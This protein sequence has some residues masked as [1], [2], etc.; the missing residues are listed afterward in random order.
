[1]AM[2]R[3]VQKVA[4]EVGGGGGGEFRGGGQGMVHFRAA[5]ARPGGHRRLRAPLGVRMGPRKELC[6]ALARALRQDEMSGKSDGRGAN[7][8]RPEGL[9]GL[10]NLALIRVAQMLSP[11]DALQL[12]SSC[13]GTR[14]VLRGAQPFSQF[15]WHCLGL[16][17][18]RDE[19]RFLSLEAFEASREGTLLQGSLDALERSG[20]EPLAAAALLRLGRA[21]LAPSA[22]QRR[23][24]F[25]PIRRTFLRVEGPGTTWLLRRLR[26]CAEGRQPVS[27]LRL[28]AEVRPT[29]SLPG[30]QS[31][32]V[33]GLLRAAVQGGVSQLARGASGGSS[34]ELRP[35]FWDDLGECLAWHQQLAASPGVRASLSVDV[36]AAVERLLATGQGLSALRVCLW[37]VEFRVEFPAAGLL[38]RVVRHLVAAGHSLPEEA[39]AQIAAW[40][41]ADPILR[42]DGGLRSR[43]LN[44]FGACPTS[45]RRAV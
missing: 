3:L 43:A 26:R 33:A 4:R 17:V 16:R 24:Q 42:Q 7:A 44:Y 6:A 28:L 9:A 13:R 19:D 14:R 32:E 38:P 15:A 36:G 25:D 30:T 8:G 41:L 27:V 22:A 18:L 39:R 1:M 35:A 34:G 29:L 21:W 5:T 20:L 23:L 2:G 45:P 40:A 12:S 37:A 11:R 31:D 10:D